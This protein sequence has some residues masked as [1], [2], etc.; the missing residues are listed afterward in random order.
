VIGLAFIDVVLCVSTTAT[1]IIGHHR[2]RALTVMQ[3][4]PSWT[5]A[6]G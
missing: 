5:D 2:G 6:R 3:S 4:L 1:V